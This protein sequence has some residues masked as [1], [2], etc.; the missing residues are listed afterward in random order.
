MEDPVV[1]DIA[2]A[3][4]KTSAQVLLRF[5]IQQVIVVIKS[6]NVER[7]KQNFYVSCYSGNLLTNHD[8]FRGSI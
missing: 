2:K 4:G 8:V 7:L 5:L 3:H 6:T 1:V